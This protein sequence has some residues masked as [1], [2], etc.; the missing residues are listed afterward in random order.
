VPTWIVVAVPMW[1]LMSLMLGV[2]M[3]VLLRRREGPARPTALAEPPPVTRVAVPPRA[4]ATAGTAC[5][6]RTHQRHLPRL[7]R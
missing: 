6:R 7:G 1:V 4:R 3:G 5:Q 2:S